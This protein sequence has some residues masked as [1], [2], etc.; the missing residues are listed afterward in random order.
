MS[1]PSE[2]TNMDDGQQGQQGHGNI[3]PG[4]HKAG[5]ALGL[6]EQTQNT[7]GQDEQARSEDANQEN[8]G[9]NRRTRD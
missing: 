1:E 8:A 4:Q 5:V 3:P 2:Q 9:G 6:S 7:G